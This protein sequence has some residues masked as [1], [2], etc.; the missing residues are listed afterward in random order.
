MK[1]VLII[2]D[3]P[4]VHS[5]V[6]ILVQG[7]LNGCSLLD[8]YNGEDGIALAASELPDVIL[9][10][11]GMP[12]ID[13]FETCRRL[14]DD[15]RTGRIPVIIFSGMATDQ[16]GE[17]SAHECGAAIVLGKPIRKDLLIEKLQSGLGP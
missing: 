12:G 14:K 5:I 13:G 9:L 6:S 16:D 11:V 17:S 3:D 1:K 10:D 15:C 7:R 4:G 2:D 8:A